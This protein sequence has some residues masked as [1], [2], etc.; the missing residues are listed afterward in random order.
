MFGS[1]KLFTERMSKHKVILEPYF[2]LSSCLVHRH[3][4]KELEQVEVSKLI[5][6]CQPTGVD[7]VTLLAL[8]FTEEIVYRGLEEGVVNIVEM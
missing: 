7:L 5:N 1:F 8:Q 3:F 2:L 6:D 4:I